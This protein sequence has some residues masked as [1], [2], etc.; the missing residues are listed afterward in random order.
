MADKEITTLSQTERIALSKDIAP[1]VADLGLIG[2][3]VTLDYANGPRQ[4]CALNVDT[5]FNVTG[6]ADMDILELGI[7]FTN[8]NL[9]LDF[10]ASVKMPAAARAALPIALLQF[11]SYSMIFQKRGG[12]WCLNG[13]VQGPT[14]ENED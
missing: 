3:G 10:D 12:Y 11:Q 7:A 14:D 2:E 1:T 4:Y 6:G 9:N 8:T 5:T 13:P